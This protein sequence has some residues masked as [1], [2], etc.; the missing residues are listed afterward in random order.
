MWQKIFNQIAMMFDYPIFDPEANHNALVD[1]AY[2][3]AGWEITKQAINWLI[4][5]LDASKRRQI[6]FMDR[7]EI[8]NLF[9]V[10]NLEIATNSAMVD[11]IS[12]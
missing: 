3:I 1:H 6:I 4:E 10:T 5:N 7:D 12:F 8:V 11:E 2:V 9:V